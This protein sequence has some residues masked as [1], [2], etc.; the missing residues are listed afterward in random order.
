MG[1]MSENRDDR[2]ALPLGAGFPMDEEAEDD[3][4]VVAAAA[5]AAADDE[6]GD[7]RI[8]A[9]AID[10]TSSSP[11]GWIDTIW[12]ASLHAATACARSGDRATAE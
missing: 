7:A 12:R 5:A 6:G 2:V 4:A 10:L 11:V 8:G 3:A 9:M 1:A